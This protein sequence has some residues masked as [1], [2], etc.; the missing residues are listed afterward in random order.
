MFEFEEECKQH[1]EARKWGLLR[2]V[3]CSEYISLK[4]SNDFEGAL[5]YLL[6]TLFYDLS[7]MGNHNNVSK[8]DSL[9]W[10]FETRLWGD[11]SLLL[12]KLNLSDTGLDTIF[13]DS[14]SQCIA[15]PP[16]SYFN[17]DIMVLIII[18]H[19]HQHNDLLEKYRPYANTPKIG[20]KDYYFYDDTKSLDYNLK[21]GLFDK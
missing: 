12:K 14:I 17:D 21:H 13:K 10:V 15:R 11:L 20:S 7:G 9:K 6:I 4:K 2:N 3:Y 18:D 8:Y 19:L 1:I 16:F 5:K